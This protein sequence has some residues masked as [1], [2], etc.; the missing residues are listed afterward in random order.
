MGVESDRSGYL[1]RV[2]G[3]DLEIPVVLYLSPSSE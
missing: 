2:S 1:V 3:D